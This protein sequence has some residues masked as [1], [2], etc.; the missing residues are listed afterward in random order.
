MGELTLAMR[1]YSRTVKKIAHTVWACNKSEI[2]DGVL[3]K[4]SLTRFVRVTG[5]KL[6]MGLKFSVVVGQQSSES[7]AGRLS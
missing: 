5:A 3:S 7:V 6:L 4:N 2:T 1:P